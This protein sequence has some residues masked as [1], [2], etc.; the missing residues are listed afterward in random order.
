MQTEL[1]VSKG[2]P[3]AEVAFSLLASSGTAGASLSC[4]FSAG[5]DLKESRAEL[6]GTSEQGSEGLHCRCVFTA[7]PAACTLCKPIK[8]S[9]C[10]VIIF[11]SF[12]G[13]P[14]FI[15]SAHKA[16]IQLISSYNESVS[17]YFFLIHSF[18][19]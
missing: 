13:R 11:K 8:R 15:M 2:G 5:K 12:F 10:T 18:F 3:I 17:C 19:E 16:G 9:K 7:D 14:S 1:Q 6:Q 4:H